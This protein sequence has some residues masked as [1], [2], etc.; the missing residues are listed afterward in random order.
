MSVAEADCLE[1]GVISSTVDELVVIESNPGVP[2]LDLE[3]VLFLEKGAKALGKV[4]DVI[5]PVTRPYYVV[6]FNNDQHI[7]EKGV[8][9]GLMVYYAPRTEHTTFVFLEQLM[10]MKRR[11]ESRERRKRTKKVIRILTR[12]Q[13]PS[14]EG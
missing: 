7:Q 3:T 1:V 11:G 12:V 9:K 6:R 13:A 2:A 8:T 5:G 4:F 10:M 14:K